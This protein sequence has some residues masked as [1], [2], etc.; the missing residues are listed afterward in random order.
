MLF[1]F[2]LFLVLIVLSLLSSTIY[3]ATKKVNCPQ[4]KITNDTCPAAEK[5]PNCKNSRIRRS[6]LG[7]LMNFFGKRSTL[8]V[9]DNLLISGGDNYDLPEA[10]WTYDFYTRT[11]KNVLTGSY[12]LV[13]D[14]VS[15]TLDGTL[16]TRFVFLAPANQ[17]SLENNPTTCITWDG[18]TVST[19]SCNKWESSF[20][21]DD[22]KQDVYLGT[23]NSI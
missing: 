1:V 6:F 17:F 4:T 21:V 22:K 2:K 15:V 10:Q 3:L 16:A 23:I 19:A 8:I 14:G 12:L 11:L 20:F 18:T 13:K 7:P 5:C 9:K